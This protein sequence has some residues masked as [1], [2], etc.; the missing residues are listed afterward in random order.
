MMST[1][2][3]FLLESHND[4][5]KS[6]RPARFGPIS[7]DYVADIIHISLLLPK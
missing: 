1:N 3:A 7:C 5:Q 2:V 4:L 6:Y